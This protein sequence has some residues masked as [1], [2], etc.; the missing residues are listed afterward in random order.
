MPY[1]EFEPRSLKSKA[2]IVA[3]APGFGMNKTILL[4]I[5]LTKCSART[6][7]NT[8]TTYFKSLLMR[9]STCLVQCTKGFRCPIWMNILWKY[10][11]YNVRVLK[12]PVSEG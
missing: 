9:K 2:V 4:A 10:K 12:L 1:R 11:S 5:A 8:L 6:F 3:Y 7:S